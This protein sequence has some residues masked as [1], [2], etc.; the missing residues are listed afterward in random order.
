MNKIIFWNVEH[1]SPQA[2]D[3]AE[4]AAVAAEVR[5]AKKAKTHATSK[6]IKEKPTRRRRAAQSRKST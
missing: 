6:G 1:L 3:I 2:A 5:L 4:E